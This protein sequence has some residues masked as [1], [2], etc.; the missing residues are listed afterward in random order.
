MQAWQGQR[1]PQGRHG[2]GIQGGPRDPSQPSAAATQLHLGTQPLPCTSSCS[3]V[4]YCPG[5]RMLSVCE[6]LEPCSPC[7]TSPSPWRKLLPMVAAPTSSHQPIIPMGCPTQHSVHAPQ[8]SQK[9]HPKP[10][11]CR[12]TH[13]IQFLTS[14]LW[15]GIFGSPTAAHTPGG[16]I[17]PSLWVQDGLRGGAE[18]PCIELQQGDAEHL[19]EHL[20]ALHI[21]KRPQNNQTLAPKRGHCWA[22]CTAVPSRQGSAPPRRAPSACAHLLLPTP[23]VS[24]VNDLTKRG[25][26]GMTN[27]RYVTAH[28]SAHSKMICNYLISVMQITPSSP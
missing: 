6:L 22:L 13:E 24:A 3:H 5:L 16:Q 4:P 10:F 18:H 26:N 25:L 15:R 11:S 17:R 21:R 8:Q 27:K 1:C 12:E 19:A 23:V 2:D 7:L 9:W 14:C 20:G 28:A